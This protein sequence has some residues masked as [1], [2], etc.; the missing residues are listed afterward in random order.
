MTITYI[1]TDNVGI[2]LGVFSTL[3]LAQKSFTLAYSKLFK[4]TF[5][6]DESKPSKSHYLV[7]SATDTVVGYIMLHEVRNQ[8]EH[9]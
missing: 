4:P 3:E 9:L 5:I 7:S 8:V 2:I 6:K 1:C